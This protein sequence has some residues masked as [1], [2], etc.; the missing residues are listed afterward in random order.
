MFQEKTDKHNV[1]HKKPAPVRVDFNR[2]IST[3]MSDDVYESVEKAFGL[4]GFGGVIITN[5]PDFRKTREKV[6]KNMYALSKEPR[7]VLEAITKTDASGLH[8]TGWSERKMNS[9]FGKSSNKFVSFYSRYPNETV[10]F[11]EDPEFEKGNENV[12]PVT[13]P[14][15]REDLMN[16]N[17]LLSSPLL[18]LLKYF[19]RYLS[20]KIDADKQGKF[21]NSFLNHYS[22]HHR[23]IGYSPLDEFGKDTEDQYLWDNWHTDFGLMGTVVH[24]IYLTRQGEK[25]DLNTTGYVL[26]DRHG[27]EHPGVFSEDEFMITAGDAMFIES[28]GYIPATPHTVRISKGMPRDLYRIQSV[29]FF[30]PNMSYRMNIPTGE[31]FQEIIQRDPSGYDHRVMDDFK[32][33]CYYKE[34]I[35][36]LLE[37]LYK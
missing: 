9:P 14:E 8:E 33:G 4:D 30:D 28:A 19:D 5:A 26:K 13:I 6:L 15:F 27:R 11:P 36:G 22:C 21:V 1:G 20:G 29:C 7:E 34:F 16:L 12:W 10:V 25:Q 2:L 3:E 18:G 24:P 17:R 35:D 32:E 31:S 23:L 37:F